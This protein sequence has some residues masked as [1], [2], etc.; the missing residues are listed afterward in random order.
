MENFFISA[1]GLD[2]RGVGPRIMLLTLPFILAALICEVFDPSFARIGFA[3]GSFLSFAGWFWLG[4]GL[5]AFIITMVQF[6]VNFPKGKLIT[7]GMYGLSRN[8]I[9]SSWTLFVL[10]GLGLILSNWLFILSAL[11]MGLAT[12]ILVKEEEQQLTGCFGQQYTDYKKQVGCIIT[13]P[14]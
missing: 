4:T 14:W 13:M 3:S 1:S 12:I 9:Y 7:T 2:A 11:V 8:P 10:P 5:T 6:I